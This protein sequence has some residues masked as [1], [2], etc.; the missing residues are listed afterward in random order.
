[1]PESLKFCTNISLYL[2]SSN[3]SNG[4]VFEVNPVMEA[5]SRLRTRQT[6]QQCKLCDHVRRPPSSTNAGQSHLKSTIGNLR[7]SCCFATS[8]RNASKRGYTLHHPLQPQPH[9]S[10][11]PDI[12]G[13]GPGD[14][15]QRFGLQRLRNTYAKFNNKWITKF[16][17][18]TVRS[19]HTNRCL[20]VLK[21]VT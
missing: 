10:E 16:L 17:S 1:M 11:R 4:E 5:R 2:P 14:F 6:G 21:L 18:T 20:P 19:S 13:M 3:N 12:V 15:C 9:S 8:Q 7:S